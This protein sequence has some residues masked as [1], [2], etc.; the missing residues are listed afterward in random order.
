MSNNDFESRLEILERTVNR[1]RLI[2]TCMGCALLVLIGMAATGAKDVSEEIRAKKIVIVDD[3]GENAIFLG[4]DK[5][6]GDLA[7]FRDRH[8]V[9]LIESQADGGRL[10]LKGNYGQPSVDLSAGPSGGQ[11]SLVD[12]NGKMHSV[13]A[14]T[15][16]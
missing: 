13:S 5:Q 1:Y 14:E 15:L 4:A 7:V 12:K 3:R 2:A 9:V 8:P 10:L 6:G 16:K 11:L